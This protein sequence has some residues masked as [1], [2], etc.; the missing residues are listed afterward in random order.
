MN[1]FDTVCKSFSIKP[2][3]AKCTKKSVHQVAT[4]DWSDSDKDCSV[5][6]VHLE[7]NMHSAH[8]VSDSVH[9]TMNIHGKKVTFQLDSGATCNI[10]PSSVIPNMPQL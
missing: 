6:T 1:H 3:C 4:S 10:L 5:W 8:S 9:A 7:E 2:S